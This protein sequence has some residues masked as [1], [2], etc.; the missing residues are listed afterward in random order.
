MIETSRPL[1]NDEINVVSGAVNWEV[2][3]GGLLGVSGA[4][5]ALAAA[6]ETGGASL[7][8]WAA[9]ASLSGH[10]AVAGLL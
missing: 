1:S 2:V 6:P 5:L 8:A 4:A 10:I 9:M 3:G 7:V